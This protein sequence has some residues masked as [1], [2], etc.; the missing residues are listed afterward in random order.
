MK[1]LTRATNFCC[2]TLLG[3]AAQAQDTLSGVEFFEHFGVD[4]KTTQIRTET[5][6]PGLHVLFGAGG[7]VVASIGEQGVLIVDDQFSAMVPRIS[8]AIQA[9]GGGNIDF[10][11]NTHWHFDHADGNTVLAN[12]GSW[13][14]SQAPEQRRFLDR[15]GSVP[16]C[17]APLL[18]PER[19]S[20]R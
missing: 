10:V 11:I 16:L 17:N 14:I 12:S 9:L 7:N 1:I 19:H 20:R 4:I 8:A 2:C 15:N 3:V 6:A 13:I 5:V 18:L